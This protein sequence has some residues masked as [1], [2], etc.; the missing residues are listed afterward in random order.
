MNKRRFILS[1]H[2]LC[3]GL[4]VL[5]LSGCSNLRSEYQRPAVTLPNAW[6]QATSGHAVLAGERWWHQ[7][8]DPTLDGLLTQVLE[9][10]NDLA[11]TGLKLQ[12]A[13]L[14]ANLTDSNL[15]PTPAVTTHSQ[16]TKALDSARASTQ[17][18]SASAELSYELDLWGRLA[19]QR[20]ASRWEA[21]ATAQDRAA[22]E[23]SLIGTTATLYW[24]IAYLNE[25]IALSEASLQDTQRALDLTR[26][27]Y[28]AGAISGLDLLQAQQ[29]VTSQE[30]ELTQSRQQRVAQRHALALLFDGPP[31]Q[32]LVERQSLHTLSVP[33]VPA[34]LPADLLAR[35]PDLR[36][37]EL[38]LRSTLAKA[39]DTRLSLYPELTLTGSGGSSSETLSKLL[40][41]PV[42]ALGASVT[43]PFVDWHKQQ[44]KVQVADNEYAQAVVSFRQSLYQALAEVEDSLSARVYYQQQAHYLTQS[45]ALAKRSEQL[46]EVR[47]RQGATGVQEWLDEQKK[48]R[49]GESALAQ[50]RQDQLNNQMKLYQALGGGV[51]K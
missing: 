18:H 50:N 13:R 51:P 17:S 48:R 47:Y 25:T 6:Q 41:N 24:Q 32:T 2:T 35:R 46:A 21:E 4:L 1:G 37:S 33:A 30:A 44:L 3:L 39:D 14:E 10:N 7:F 29:Q 9:R 49:D 40:S 20:D 38:R 8:G 22:T 42:G 28:Q 36:A 26:V 27:K 5:S 34:G 31:E 23:L 45:L 43:L 16:V 19:S 11:L 15:Y 12:Q